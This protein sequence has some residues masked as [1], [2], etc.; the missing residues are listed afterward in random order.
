[1]ASD[2]GRNRSMPKKIGFLARGRYFIS[3]SIDPIDWKNLF[4]SVGVGK[5]MYLVSPEL[6]RV[7]HLSFL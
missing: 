7:M 6:S 2:W 4:I 3:L 5:N 1:M